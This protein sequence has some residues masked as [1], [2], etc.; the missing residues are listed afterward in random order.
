ME[1]SR[2]HCN[3]EWSLLSSSHHVLKASYTYFALVP[4]APV[5][6]RPIGPSVSDA[7]P[8]TRRGWGIGCPTTLYVGHFTGC[9]VVNVPKTFSPHEQKPCGWSAAFLV[10]RPAWAPTSFLQSEEVLQMITHLV[11]A[12]I[13]TYT[14]QTTYLLKLY[15]Q[16]CRCPFGS[17]EQSRHCRSLPPWPACKAR[18]GRC[19]LA[20]MSG[21]CCS[22]YWSRPSRQRRAN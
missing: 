1:I 22:K 6:V 17:I 20:S 16:T 21:R 10:H 3:Q 11:D 19:T 7:A 18:G 9:R 14:L 5:Y 2:E 13:Y 12:I 15:K 8:G 4:P